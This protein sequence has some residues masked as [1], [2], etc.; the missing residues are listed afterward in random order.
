M[1]SF[2]LKEHRRCKGE[3]LRVRIVTKSEKAGLQE[4]W[5]QKSLEAVRSSALPKNTQSRVL[6]MKLS[7]A[8]QE[9][10]AACLKAL[11]LQL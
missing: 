4:L 9:L 7:S 1:V 6:S 8:G 10:G 11:G 2:N 3:H 5:P